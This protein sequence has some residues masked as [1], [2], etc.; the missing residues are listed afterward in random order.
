[1]IFL[2]AGIKSTATFPKVTLVA[3][4]SEPGIHG[5]LHTISLEIEHPTGNCIGRCIV[6]PADCVTFDERGSTKADLD[7]VLR[8][9][10]DGA[11]PGDNIVCNSCGDRAIRRD[12]VLLIIGDRIPGDRHRQIAAYVIKWFIPNLDAI[13]FLTTAHALID[14]YNYVICDRALGAVEQNST[15]TVIATITN[16]G[17]V[18]SGDRKVGHCCASSTILDHRALEVAAI[19]ID[20]GNAVACPVQGAAVGDQDRLKRFSMN[21]AFV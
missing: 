7:A 15:Q 19:R 5:C 13:A 11:S 9:V 16:I 17:Q 1:M 10:I 18:G 21:I 3:F 12:P 2:W 20:R 4:V 6:I 14:I 8:N